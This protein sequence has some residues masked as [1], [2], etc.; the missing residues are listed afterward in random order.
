MINHKSLL[1]CC[2]AILSYY[3]N[4][5]ENKFPPGGNVGIGTGDNP[6]ARLHIIT[7][8]AM[9]NVW[10][11][12]GASS[13]TRF[14]LETGNGYHTLGTVTNHPLILATNNAERMRIVENGNVG[15]GT[16]VPLTIMDIRGDKVTISGTSSFNGGISVF[17]RLFGVSANE[18][19]GNY[20]SS[21]RMNNFEIRTSEA[22]S[23]TGALKA[24]VDN[25]GNAFFN[26]NMGIGTASPT[27]RLLSVNGNI[28]TKKVRVTQTGWP[29]YVFEEKYPLLPLPEL[30]QFIQSNKHLPEIPTEKEVNENGLD[31]GDMNALLLKKVEELT[32]YVIDLQKQVDALKKQTDKKSRN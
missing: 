14:K 30:S 1:F 22:G 3:A 31:L 23:L 7:P 17:Y 27:E 26:G 15:I 25:S 5:Q 11:D 28:V 29:D 13:A 20:G 4:A 21:L 10:I 8:S 32:L 12:Y 9:S 24:S 18:L 16:G 2:I 6:G 19:L